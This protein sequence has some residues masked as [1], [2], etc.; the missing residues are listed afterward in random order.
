MW[1]PEIARRP[2]PR[3]VVIAEALAED[4][5][6]GRLRP[7]MRLP[8]HRE[9]ADR[10]GVTVGTVTRAY[11]E[12]ARRGLVSG[13]VGRGT[14]VRRAAV[15]EMAAPPP[16]PGLVDLSVNHPPPLAGES[17]IPLARTLTELA[18]RRD[19]SELLAYPPE[20]GSAEHRDAG[21]R[22]IRGAGLPATP[23]QVLVSS[24]SQHG[25]TAVFSA[26]LRPGDVVATESV[27]YP[28]MRALAGLLH[29]R[30][31]GLPMDREGLLPD[32]FERACRSGTVKALYAIPT[33]QNPT[34]AVL[35]EARRRELARIA[36]AH[37]VL[38][39][40]DD[41]H[42]HLLEDAPR[43]LASFAP[44]RSVYLTGTA[45][46]LAPGLRVGFLHAPKA[47]V[48][49]LSAAIRATTW[50]APPLTAEIAA[51]WIR[52]GTAEAIVR[53][54]R[55]EAA[56]RHKLAAEAL[57]GFDFDSHPA[58]YH[59]WLH[60]PEPWRGE[61]FADAARRRGVLVT[62]PAAFAVGRG[63]PDAV[64]VCLGGTS[65]RVELE[66]GIEALSNLL[67][68]PAEGGVLAAAGP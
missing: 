6:A 9:L 64:R 33:L 49:R 21:A 39:V 12:A 5:A 15:A 50:M 52:D 31:L 61:A 11:A 7:G 1:V 59:L 28:G 54:R 35:P 48:P 58:A 34:A 8:T 14:F 17:S 53:R 65:D 60:L 46:S 51:A 36:E 37:G 10:L 29:L 42:G 38:I 26:L 24:G 18:R 32:A 40:E 47:L 27:T 41:V 44:E 30:L 23:E 55:K 4:A 45:K 2:G 57:S 62:P 66:R 68:F 56:A 16:P 3:Y 22:W 25:M 67:G 43:P 13:E 63:M 19:L 20:G